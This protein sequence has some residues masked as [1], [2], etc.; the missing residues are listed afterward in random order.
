[1]TPPGTGESWLMPWQAARRR[2]VSAHLGRV[3]ED[4]Q[5]VSDFALLGLFVHRI[6]PHETAPM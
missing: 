5:A 6:R 3:A 4:R 2:R 1:M